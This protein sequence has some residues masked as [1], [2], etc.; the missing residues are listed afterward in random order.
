[1]YF[2]RILISNFGDYNN[3]LTN[4][5]DNYIN[6]KKNRIF[7]NDP[8]SVTKPSN[9]FVSTNMENTSNTYTSYLKTES[10]DYFM[11]SR[12]ES[13][14]T[15]IEDDPTLS[16]NIKRTYE[17]NNRMGSGIISPLD[18]PNYYS[19]YD[20][21]LGSPTKLVSSYDYPLSSPIKIVSPTLSPYLANPYSDKVRLNS[22]FEDVEY[23]TSF[24]L[25]DNTNEFGLNNNSNNNYN[26]KEI[27]ENEDEDVIIHNK[28]NNSLLN[29]KMKDVIPNTL[30]LPPF[31]T[32]KEYNIKSNNYKLTSDYLIDESESVSQYSRISYSHQ[33]K[34][35]KGSFYFNTGKENDSSSQ[36]NRNSLSH[37]KKMSKGS[38]YFPT[39]QSQKVY[40]RSINSIIDPSKL[41]VS[42]SINYHKNIN[43]INT[44]NSNSSYSSNK[45]SSNNNNN[46]NIKNCNDDNKSLNFNQSYNLNDDKSFNT[47]SS[48]TS[49]IQS[50]FNSTSS[51]YEKVYTER[52]IDKSYDKSYDSFSDQSYNSSTDKLCDNCTD[53]SLKNNSI[54][55]DNSINNVKNVNRMLQ[56]MSTLR[57][58][59]TGLIDVNKKFKYN[60]S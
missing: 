59:D 43:S 37:K 51:S 48:I 11:Y 41:N 49:F 6:L 4:N 60:N 38:F 56:K 15:N 14:N 36:Y 54:T 28:E 12:G 17:N 47:E 39:S 58:D 23:N 9:L 52:N 26:N 8:L 42:N 25:R 30:T 55:E 57:V 45:N 16:N 3:Q 46:N 53:V 34:E 31:R 33:S 50:N 10:P 13:S 1:M 35:S 20:T 32:D 44:N 29:H 21:P 18:S 5:R 27:E 2:D 24:S 22:D 40:T 19:P 7:K